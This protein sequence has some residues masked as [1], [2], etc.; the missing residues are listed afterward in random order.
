MP[1][2]VRYG[3]RAAEWS[4]VFRIASM[5][6][7]STLVISS[8][9]TTNRERSSAVKERVGTVGPDGMVLEG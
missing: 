8:G 1:Q 4:I 5:S 7:R 6:C 9:D 3:I 2:R